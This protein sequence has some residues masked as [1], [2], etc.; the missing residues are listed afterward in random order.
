MKELEVNSTIS[1]KGINAIVNNVEQ[2]DY[3]LFKISVI[4]EN[5]LYDGFIIKN[6]QESSFKSIFFNQLSII[7]NKEGRNIQILI[8]SYVI[9]SESENNEKNI[10]N[11]YDLSKFPKFL[12]NNEDKKYDSGIFFYKNKKDYLITLQTFEDL[13][14]IEGKINTKNNVYLKEIEKF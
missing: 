10:K 5:N 6:L 3:N 1:F 7:K 9:I 8:N 13:K 4:I 11:I 2:I 14:E 12:Y